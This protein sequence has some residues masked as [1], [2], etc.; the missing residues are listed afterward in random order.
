MLAA[1]VTTGAAAAETPFGVLDITLGASYARLERDLDF[2]DINASLAKTQSGKPDLGK[3]GYGCM[4]RDDDFADVGCVSHTERLDGIDTREIRLHFL[5]GRLQ[6][7]SLTAEVQNFDAVVAYLR[8]RYGAPQEMPVQNAGDP[9][10][11]RWRSDAGQIVAHR[12][13][14]LVF[15]NFELASY[16]DAVKRKHDGQR[17]QCA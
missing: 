13:K 3:R 14:D 4:Q 6:Q 10:S 15:V 5:D 7:F 17:L 11:V 16:P 2:H 8:G 12:G 9:P 1:A